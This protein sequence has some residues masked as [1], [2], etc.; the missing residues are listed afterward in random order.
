[1]YCVKCGVELSSSLTRC[2][3]CGTRVLIPPELTAGGAG[4]KNSHADAFEAAPYP[5]RLSPEAVSRSG[6]ATALTV[7]FL[8]PL[9]VCL[10]IDLLVTHRITFSGYVAGG[11]L[12]GY[13]ALVLPLWFKRPN[14][15]V[16]VPITL[17]LAICLC[18]YISLKTH[19]GWFLS[20]AFP[21]GGAVLLLVETLVVL[22][23]YLRKG[24]LFVIG[25]ALL[26][27]GGLCLLIEFLM[28]VTFGTAM[29]WWSLIPLSVLALLGALFIVVGAVPS[30]RH[31][32]HQKLFI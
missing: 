7:V 16:F 27:L 20:F 15:V 25:G 32:L 6:A 30:L 8:I 26:F 12:V 5:E 28:H 1:M 18:L 13:S 21:V 17:G 22:F 11:L 2:P 4:G 19:G 14:P 29:I 10:L 24:H 31:K 3:L 23:K 9:F